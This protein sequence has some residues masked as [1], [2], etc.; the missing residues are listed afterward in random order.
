LVAVASPARA[1][2]RDLNPFNRRLSRQED[3]WVKAQIKQMRLEEKIGQLIMVPIQGRFMNVDSDE[4]Q[5][6]RSLI[7]EKRIGGIV[8]GIG[9]VYETAILIDRLQELARVSLLVAADFEAG[10]AMRLRDTTSFPWNMAVGATE[11]ITL[12]ERQGEITAKE[13]RAVGINMIFAPVADVNNNPANPVI[14]VRSYGE[15]PQ[16]VAQFVSA[17]IRGAQRYGVIATAKH[18]P[19]H[20]DTQVDSHRGLPVLNVNRPRLDATELV[21]FKAAITAGA[22]AVMTAHVALPQ[23]DPTPAPPRRAESSVTRQETPF[24][25]EFAGSAT[26][27]AT[28]SAPILT[29][30]LRTELKFTG[31]IVTDSMEM[32]GIVAH[33]GPG[34]AAVRAVKAGADILLMR[35]SVEQA[36]QGLLDAVRRGN[37]KEDQINASV[38][39]ILGAKVRLG[40]IGQ[41]FTDLD[42]V[43]TTVSARESLRVVQSV[44][45]KSITLVRNN[46]LLVP[47]PGS[48]AKGI[49]HIAVTDKDTNPE[50][51]EALGRD[52]TGGLKR[53]GLNVEVAVVEARTT[54]DEAKRIVQRADGVDVVIMSLF[55]R[56]RS[57]RGSIGLPET[58]AQ[59]LKGLL[60]AQRPLIVISFGSPYFLLDYP[61]IQTYVCAFGDYVDSVPSQRAVARALMGEIS[62]TGKLPVSLPGLYLRGHGIQVPPREVK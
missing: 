14:N 58:G 38:E 2:R 25:L 47:L 60:E 18:F 36:I 55:V 39:R 33:F 13:A 51:R 45:E 12:A 21:P 15:D 26:V 46:Q 20:G 48:L 7:L 59:V 35:P 3:A 17:F 54:A 34:D 22:G 6:L 41:R 44:A 43:D 40:I 42:M 53:K 10:T 61:A 32:G 19:G 23:L 28:L 29:G 50:E 31:L 52:L 4:F 56:P 62:I 24:E 49:L 57:G 8:T 11:D 30:L 27:P 16:P 37:L 5:H 9:P 1:Q